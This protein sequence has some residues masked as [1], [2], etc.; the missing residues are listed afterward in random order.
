[1]WFM[2][3]RIKGTCY[4]FIVDG[5]QIEFFDCSNNTYVKKNL[6]DNMQKLESLLGLNYITDRVFS[7]IAKYNNKVIFAPG[8]EN[9]LLIYDEIE[10]RTEEIVLDEKK[11][12]SVENKYKFCK[13]I[14][15]DEKVYLF[16][17]S[18]VAIVIVD[19][20]T[21]QIDYIE[22]WYKKAGL[23]QGKWAFCKVGYH[24]CEFCYLPFTYQNKVMW[25]N[26]KTAEY[27]ILE[28]PGYDGGFTCMGSDGDDIWLAACFQPNVYRWNREAN[29]VERFILNPTIHTE[30]GYSDIFIKGDYMILCPGR[31]KEIWL[32]N[33]KN[34]LLERKIDLPTKNNVYEK[35]VY[36]S[37]IIL[38]DEQ[39]L[40]GYSCE[41]GMFLKICIDTGE[42]FEYEI[43]YSEE[44]KF[45]IIN[46]IFQDKC[47]DNICVENPIL[48][49]KFFVEKVKRTY[50]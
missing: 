39:Y 18:A 4:D 42:V 38:L 27:Q 21:Y 36:F 44:D 30:K 12:S 31:G 45:D 28:V 11:I 24:M 8:T 29:N 35:K 47:I 41:M 50:S 13:S 34:R 20:K 25:F 48:D 22:D 10:K 17:H 5:N 33:K 16:P 6:I 3:P 43:N 37:H 7:S 1:M 26:L 23:E 19:L 9:R 14:V 46:R 49:L 15:W 32:W 2:N 40:F